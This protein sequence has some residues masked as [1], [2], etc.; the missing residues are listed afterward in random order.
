MPY[1]I[2]AQAARPGALKLSKSNAMLLDVGETLEEGDGPQDQ[3]N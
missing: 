1:F 2:W 3:R